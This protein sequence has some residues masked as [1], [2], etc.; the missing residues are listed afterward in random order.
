MKLLI[1]L[2]VLI[3]T[4]CQSVSIQKFPMPE[5]NMDLVSREQVTE[6]LNKYDIKK[7]ELLDS[8]YAIV[9]DD[10]AIKLAEVIT[11][12]AT[13]LNYNYKSSSADCD[14]FAR[15]F[16][17]LFKYPFRYSEAEPIIFTVLVHQN[18][19]WAHVGSGGNHALVLIFT[20]KGIRLVEPNGKGVTC[21][22]KDYPNR[23]F[24]YQ[25]L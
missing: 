5:E 21:L 11:F 8:V 14:N 25:L 7:P 23:D 6:E 15:L 9:D 13:Y 19:E 24:I 20:T 12:L 16:V 1:L 18:N 2:I 22:L 3:I 4:G 10:Y 17:E